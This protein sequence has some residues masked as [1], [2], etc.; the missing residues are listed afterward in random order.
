MSL[1]IVNSFKLLPPP[2]DII[3]GWKEVGRTTAG[4]TITDLDVTGIADKRYYMIL[5]NLFHNG[6]RSVIMETGNGSFDSGSNYASRRSQDGGTDVTAVSRTNMILNDAQSSTQSFHV[7][8][9]ANLSAKEKL[10]QSQLIYQGT[11]GAANAPNRA[12]AANKWVNTSNPLDRISYN[13]QSWLTGSECVVL[14]WDPDDTHTTN[15]WEELASVDLSGGAASTLDTGTF[16]AKK[17]LWIQVYAEDNAGSTINPQ[18]TVNS[19]GTSTYARRQSTNGAAESL[20]VSQTQWTFR[21]TQGSSPSWSNIFLVNNSAK[22]KIGIMHSMERAT[23]GAGTAPT[24]M[25][26]VIKQSTTGS[27]ITSFQLKQDSGISSNLFG[28]NTIIKVWG[29]D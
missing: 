10:F 21:E 11:A 8:Y 12:E 2:P 6:S 5:G 16:T 20:S 28:T 4:S 17:Y 3:G 19:L 1:N 9:A 14:G 7:S 27:Q 15:F 26:G 29:S 25:V 22:E 13:D 23:A 18:Y 24:K